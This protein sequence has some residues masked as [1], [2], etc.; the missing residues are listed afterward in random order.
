MPKLEAKRLIQFWAA[1]MAERGT[2]QELPIM[3]NGET[4]LG[5]A[6][7]WAP[8]LLLQNYSG[9]AVRVTITFSCVYETMF[10]PI[11]ILPYSMS[12]SN[13]HIHCSVP[14]NPNIDPSQ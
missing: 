3:C 13:F 7:T 1:F 11:D 14:F 5:V 2:G 9:T 6:G 8:E 12:T 10:F 4:N